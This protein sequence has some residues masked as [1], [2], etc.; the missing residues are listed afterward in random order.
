MRGDSASAVWSRLDGIKR[1]LMVRI[2]RYA[3]LT[4]PK[5]CLP[6]GATTY[7]TEQSHDYQSLGA[8]AVNHVVN[9]LMVAIAAPSRPFFRVQAGPTTAKEMAAA[10]VSET[11]LGT[12]LANLE[13]DSVKELD[14]KGQRP[15]LYQALRHLVIT[16]NVLMILDKDHIRIL[17]MKYFCVKRN[18]K[19]EVHTL[20]IRESVFFDE[21]DPN[22]RKL[23]GTRYHDE[24]KVDHYK[25]IKRN[26]G[27]AGGYTMTQWIDETKLPKEW[28]ARWSEEKMPYRVLTWDLADEADYG[29]GLVEDYAGDFEAMSVL[30]QA[31]CEGGVMGTEFRW[32]VNPTGQ[33]SVDDMN[34]SRSGDTIAGN[35]KDVGVIQPNT[36]NG[37]KMAMD[38]ENKYSQRIARG[39]LLQSAVTRDAERV[40]AEEIRATAMELESSFGGVYSSLAPQLQKPLAMW[41]LATAGTALHGTDLGI[42]IITGLDAL[43]R[44]GDLENLRLALSDL[45]QLATAPPQLQGR[46][47][48]QDLS[49][50]VGQGRGVDL[51]RFIKS[52]DEYAQEQQALRAAETQQAN[53][54]AQGAAQADAQAQPPT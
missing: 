40:T 36:A 52:D 34:N 49:E 9:K 43:S 31:T 3:A 27:P 11:D 32:A 23:F 20:V 4:I 30:A 29:T 46:I 22:I 12:I 44:N 17:G 8:Q 48:W 35:P 45:A 37:V 21:L 41:L 10:K 5:V 28:D 47:K 18:V 24:T 1:A 33:T 14:A 2:E 53:E 38:L 54:Q 7:N 25:L 42:V 51:R 13:R 50:F 16:G 19:G 39:F 6:G 15:K 26:P